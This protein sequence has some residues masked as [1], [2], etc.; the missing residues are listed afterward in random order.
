M[1]QEKKTMQEIMQNT[2]QNTMKA[3][4]LTGPKQIEIAEYFVGKAKNAYKLPDTVSD[5]S[6]GLIDPLMVAYHAVKKSSFKLHDKV[7]VVGSGIIAQLIGGLV[8]KQ[9]RLLSP[10]LKLMT[11]K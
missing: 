9:V 11:G 7:L 6:A 3:G 1:Q 2:G 5:V 10:C 4:V 8:K